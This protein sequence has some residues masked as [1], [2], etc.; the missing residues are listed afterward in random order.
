MENPA[1]KAKREAE[2]LFAS[3]TDQKYSGE[4]INRFSALVDT[5]TSDKFQNYIVA[6]GKTIGMV[7]SERIAEDEK[8]Y[9]MRVPGSVLN[10]ASEMA[11][12]SFG[13]ER[14][15]QRLACLVLTLQA[16]LRAEERVNTIYATP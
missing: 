9:L 6:L 10:T 2:E 7:P 16:T 1:L 8:R 4:R 14:F 5:V 12:H 15:R 13:S 11:V 3:L